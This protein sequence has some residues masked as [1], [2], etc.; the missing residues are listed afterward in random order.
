MLHIAICD[1]EKDFVTYLTELI[2]RYAAETGEEIRI[3]PF[4]DGMELIERYDTSIDLIF[5]DIQMRLADG[6]YTAERVRQFDEEVGIIFLTTLTQYGLKGYQYQAVN[7]IIKPI[8][9]VR[10]KT[11][12]NQ[13]LKKHAQF[14]HSKNDSPAIVVVNDSGKYKVF[15]KSLRYVETFNR[16]LLLHTEQENIISYKSMKEMEQELAAAGFVR[17]HTSYL[18][19]LLYI[20]GVKKLELELITGEKLPISQPKRKAFMEQLTEYWGERL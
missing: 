6:L 18:V 1:D 10:L 8:Q 19:N 7:Y 14:G 2:E 16:K 11:E 9:Y 3:T 12:L 13:W 20:K 4:Y 5:L 15:L 17:C